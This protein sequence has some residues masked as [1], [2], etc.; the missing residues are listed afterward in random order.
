MAHDPVS[1]WRRID[2][3]ALL[4]ASL[5]AP[6]AS[7]LIWAF[8]TV[9]TQGASAAGPGNPLIGVIL[10]TVLIAGWGALPAAAFGT[11][12]LLMVQRIRPDGAPLWLLASAGMAAAG[13]YA[14]CSIALATAR[15]GWVA[16]IAPWAQAAPWTIDISQQGFPHPPMPMIASVVLSGAVGALAYHRVAK[17]RQTLRPA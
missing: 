4:V 8:W 10:F 17:R 16:L 1:G 2:A 9:V 7:F 3:F 12:L 6:A 14:G 13:L 15:Q 11:P 5:A